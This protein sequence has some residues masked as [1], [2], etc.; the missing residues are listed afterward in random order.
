MG[1]CKN[2]TCNLDELELHLSYGT[3]APKIQVLKPDEYEKGPAGL[4][5]PQAGEKLANWLYN[6]TNHRFVVSVRD[7]LKNFSF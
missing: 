6:N 4:T 7:A 3:I 2:C 5:S 1:C